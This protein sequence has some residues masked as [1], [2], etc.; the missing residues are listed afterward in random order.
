M[1]D[2][3]GA[4][5]DAQ[6][7]AQLMKMTADLHMLHSSIDVFRGSA[8][9]LMDEVEARN[10]EKFGEWIAEVRAKIEENFEV[11]TSQHRDSSVRVSELK[12]ELLDFKARGDKSIETIRTEIAA[13]HLQREQD[14]AAIINMMELVMNQIKDFHNP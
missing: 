10:M 3:K 14:E 4:D 11:C 9:H 8:Q 6:Q 12:N 13:E 5:Q 7:N 1:G 2:V